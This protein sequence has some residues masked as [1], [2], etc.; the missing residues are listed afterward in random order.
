MDTRK[1]TV[2][3]FVLFTVFA[4]IVYSAYQQAPPKAGTSTCDPDCEEHE[5][6][7]EQDKPGVLEGK[8]EQI[9]QKTATV[10]AIQLEELSSK[11]CANQI[12]NYLAQLGNIGIIKCDMATK[13][14][15]VQYNP[16]KVSKDQI[17]KAFAEAKHPGKII[18]EL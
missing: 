18:S 15:E 17:L 14:F 16:D 6:A 10:I 5:Q 3:F 12:A 4:A 9:D 13:R 8:I 2:F 11:D 7:N 1:R